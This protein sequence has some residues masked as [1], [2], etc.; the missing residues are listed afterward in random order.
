M[1]NGLLKSS[2]HGF[3][4]RKSCTTNLL[5]FMKQLTRAA[6][7]GDA[8]DVI[9]LDFVKAFDKVPHKSLLRQL[10]AHGVDGKV[11]GSAH[12]WQAENREWC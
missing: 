3:M 11:H 4:A 6:D 5:E 2:K 7:E 10:K 1:G 8:V 9:F 12:G